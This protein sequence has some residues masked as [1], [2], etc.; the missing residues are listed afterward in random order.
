MKNAFQVFTPS[1]SY[2]IYAK[3]PEEKQTWMTSILQGIE[4][5]V[6][7]SQ[8]FQTIMKNEKKE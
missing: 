2:V 7:K 4:T 6:A 8:S 1:Q 5:Q 3:S